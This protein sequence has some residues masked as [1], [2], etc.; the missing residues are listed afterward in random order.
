MHLVQT[1]RFRPDLIITDYQLPHGCT[2]DQV[3]AAIA[4]TLGNR[5]PFILLTGDI[6]REHRAALEQA[7]DRI[8]EKPAD[9]EAL[10]DAIETLSMSIAVD[11]ARRPAQGRSVEPIR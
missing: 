8:L 9:V 11:S 1:T 3:V 2:G 5:P 10:L 6:S 7:V 4:H